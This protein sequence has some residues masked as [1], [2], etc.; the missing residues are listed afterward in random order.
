MSDAD[1]W[2]EDVVFRN[3]IFHDSWNN[4]ILKINNGARRVTVEGNVFYNQTG[5]DE[6]MDVNSVT[7][8]VIQDN[9]FFNDFAGSGRVERQRHRRPSS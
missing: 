1:D 6:H 5:S 9:I 3:N 4:D 2:S 8:V 7:D